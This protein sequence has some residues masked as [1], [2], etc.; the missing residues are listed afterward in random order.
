M[1]D[2]LEIIVKALVDHPDQVEVKE[3]EEGGSVT[4][5]LHVAPSDIGK[6]IGRQGRVVKAI[7]TVMKAAAIRDNKRVSVEVLG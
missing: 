4:F 2:L 5:E 7:R 3:T 1:R 6:V